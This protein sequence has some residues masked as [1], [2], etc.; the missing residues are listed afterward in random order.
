MPQEQTEDPLIQEKH[1][2]EKACPNRTEQDKPAGLSNS[3]GQTG[4]NKRPREKGSE[5]TAAQLA[6]YYISTALCWP[7]CCSYRVLW[8][9]KV[10]SDVDGLHG[11]SVDLGLHGPFTGNAVVVDAGLRI[12]ADGA[13]LMLLA[14]F[15][16][17]LP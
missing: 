5:N 4:S 9:A 15:L 16:S 12:M 3:R 2:R 8:D 13:I 6:A 7:V 14:V 17:Q 1:Q 11:L 10:G